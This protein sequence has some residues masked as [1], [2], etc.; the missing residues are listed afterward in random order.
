MGEYILS[1]S[2][3]QFRAL[4]DS[5][6]ALVIAGSISSMPTITLGSVDV[7]IGAIEIKNQSNDDRAS[8]TGSRLW[9]DAIGSVN[10]NT[11]ITISAG[12]A[13]I[14][15]TV[16]ISGA[17]IS[18]TL[19]TGSFVTVALASG[20]WSFTT[21]ITSC[22]SWAVS[23]SGGNSYDLAMSSGTTMIPHNLGINTIWAED[24]TPS[25]IAIRT[26]VATSGMVEMWSN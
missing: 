4:V 2:G 16:A 15:N 1:G 20:T 7:Q 8:V 19:A 18:Q 24:T 9:V 17:Y 5:T 25:T 13:I 14:T 26:S 21:P 10:I 22:K 3:T 12:S 6:G 23:V 11:P